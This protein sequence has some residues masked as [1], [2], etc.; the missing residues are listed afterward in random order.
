MTTQYTSFI[1]V[2]SKFSE[3]F[4]LTSLILRRLY[5]I[6]VGRVLKRMAE[7]VESPPQMYFTNPPHKYILNFKLISRIFHLFLTVGDTEC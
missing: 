7:G 5:F 6:Q 1:L 3:N 4:E 2:W